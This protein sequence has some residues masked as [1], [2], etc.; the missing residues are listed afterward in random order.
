MSKS[1]MILGVSV[2]VTKLDKTKFI[3]GKK[4][5]V[6]A[7]LTIFVNNEKDQYGNDCSVTQSQTKEE[8]DA[9][10]KSV[11]VGNGKINWED[12]NG[13]AVHVKA[14]EGRTEQAEAIRNNSA[15]KE[16]QGL[17]F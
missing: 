5:G 17:P 8:R 11:F 3:T 6:Y 4:G 14:E 16:G 13:Q 7:N 10:A 2:D 15:D 12:P 1:K 9:K